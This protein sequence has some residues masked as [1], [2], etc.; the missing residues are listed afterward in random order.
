METED[1]A[2]HTDKKRNKKSS[3]KLTT[4]LAI[5]A[6]AAL[7]IA[8]F[9]IGR[10]IKNKNGGASQTTTEITAAATTA[11]P[12][13]QET[14]EDSA[15]LQPG[16][17]YVKTQGSTLT[18][19]EDKSADSKNID[20]I[21]NGSAVVLLQVDGEWGFVHWSRSNSETSYE[22]GWVR[23]AYLSKTAPSGSSTAAAGATKA[24]STTLVTATYVYG[25]TVAQ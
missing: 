15:V 24:A 9:I 7:L 14:T 11:V 8:G 19:R 20:G 3:D 21:P 12:T 2:I 6:V 1:S 18:M 13:T 4:I 5:A 10:V 17:Y 16:T 22:A 23:I 25:T